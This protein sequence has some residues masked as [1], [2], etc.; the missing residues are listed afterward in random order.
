MYRFLAEA[1]RIWELE[2]SKPRITTIQAGIIFNVIHN[3]CGLDEIGQAYRVH[4]IAL[5]HKI[6]LFDGTLDQHG[7]NDRMWNGKAY[8]AWAL[9]NW[10]T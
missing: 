4:A 1:K 10:E 3:L 9:Y 7:Q 5:A 6:R 2:A 8:A